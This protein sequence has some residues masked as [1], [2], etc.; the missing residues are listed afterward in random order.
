MA[1][2]LSSE[3]PISATASSLNPIRVF[4]G[5]MAR[6]QAERARRRALATLLDY[7]QEQLDDLGIDRQALLEALKLP[8]SRAGLRLAQRRAETSRNWLGL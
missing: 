8:R 4:A 7:D 5:W 1:H 2:L 6:A 3:R